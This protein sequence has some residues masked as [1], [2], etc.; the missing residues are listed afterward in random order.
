MLILEFDVWRQ[1]TYE[2]RSF[3]TVAI[4]DGMGRLRDGRIDVRC[5]RTFHEE[6]L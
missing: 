1:T 3:V 5:E 6:N 4:D 2:M